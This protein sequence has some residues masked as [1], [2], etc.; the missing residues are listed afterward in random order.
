MSPFCMKLE[1]WLRL[2]GIPFEIRAADPRKSPKGKL[3][4]VRML[5]GSLLGDSQLIVERLTREHRVTLDD[6]LTE[7][8]RATGRAVR[9]MIEEATYFSGVYAR[10]G[11]DTGWADTRVAFAKILPAPAAL[12]LPL[13]RRSVKKSLHAQ[14]IARHSLREIEDFAIADWEAVA[15]LLGEG[16]YFFGTEPTSIDAT[17]YGFLEALLAPPSASRIRDAVRARPSLV[18]YRDRMRG[19]LPPER[20]GT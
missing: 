10:W 14:G 16:P 4:Y 20:F 19:V 8:Q 11:D 6:R 15:T 18:A 3:P 2:A 7:V 5:D 17:L 12:L 9:R 13:I 1:C